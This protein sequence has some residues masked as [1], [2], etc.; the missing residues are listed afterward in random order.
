[1]F[2]TGVVPRGDER[3]GEASQ[4]LL[5]RCYLRQGSFLGLIDFGSIQL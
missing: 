2:I 3:L 5:E 1:M 4:K